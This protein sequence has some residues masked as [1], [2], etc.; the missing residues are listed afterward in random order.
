M[1]AQHEMRKAWLSLLGI[2][3]A[4][5]LSFLVGNLAGALAGMGDDTRAPVWLALLLFVVIAI[6]FAIPVGLAF[7]FGSRA[8]EAG[9][10]RAML[11]GWIAA[12]LGVVVVA[13][14]VAAY[15]VA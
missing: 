3:V 1:V 10:H 6:L 9:A 8:A 14:N 13:Q 4:L 12:V 11:P 5:V 7:V 15:F 2:P